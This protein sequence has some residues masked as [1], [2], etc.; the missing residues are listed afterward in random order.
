MDTCLDKWIC[1]DRNRGTWH[2]WSLKTRSPRHVYNILQHFTTIYLCGHGALWQLGILRLYLEWLGH[3]ATYGRALPKSWQ[4]IQKHGESRKN[5]RT[6]KGNDGNE[7]FC[8]APCM[9]AHL[10]FGPRAAAQRKGGRGTSI[11]ALPNGRSGLAARPQPPEV[12]RYLILFDGI[13]PGHLT[14]LDSEQFSCPRGGMTKRCI[15]LIVCGESHKWIC[16]MKLARDGT[17]VKQND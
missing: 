1:K 8:G 11:S 7:G 14:S 10:G 6:Y 9:S 2:F 15:H 4:I 12:A 3:L 5:K 16:N 17:C 13:C